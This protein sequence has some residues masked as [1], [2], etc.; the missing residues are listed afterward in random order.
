MVALRPEDGGQAVGEPGMR[1]QLPGLEPE[2]EVTDWGQSERLTAL[3]EATVSRWLYAYW[4]RVETEGMERVPVSGGALLLANR[5]GQLPYDAAMIAR[6]VRTGRSRS[7]HF[8]AAN[9]HAEVPGLGMVVTKLGGVLA[10]PANLLRLLHDEGALVLGFPEPGVGKPLRAR[11]RLGRFDRVEL[12]QAALRAGVPIV[13]VAVL[14]AE[15]ATPRLAALSPVRL[16]VFGRLPVTPPLPLP[17]K[18]RIRFLEPVLPRALGEAAW[19]DRG[20]AQELAQDIR[21]LIQE[22]VLELVASRRSVWLG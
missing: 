1:E 15:E 14:G 2:R 8:A 11:Y 20:L 9:P 22:N 21:A 10:H 7:V 6:A 19:R 12:I 13:P 4:F 16:P 3:V 17:A 5:S 18:V